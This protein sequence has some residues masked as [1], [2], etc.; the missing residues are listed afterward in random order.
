MKKNAIKLIAVSMAFTLGLSLVAINS[1]KQPADL[2]A[3]NQHIENYDPYTYSGNYYSS[4]DASALTE[5]LDG[6]LRTKLTTL[7][8]PTQWYKYSGSGDDTLS[9]RLQYADEDPTDSTKMVYLYTRDS[10]T[11]NAASTWNR[12]HVWPQSLSSTTSSNNW[13]EGQAGA[14]LLHI[15]PTYNSTNSDRSNDIYADTNKANPKTYNGMLYG[16]ETGTRFEPLD[17]AKGDVA[18]IIMYIW[19]AYKN[20]YQNFPEITNVFESY[21]TLLKWHT[22]DE[23][24]TLEGNRNDYVEST[25]QK[26]R[27]PFVDHPEY[28]WMIF[29]DSASANI[30]QQCK[31]KYPADGTGTTKTLTGISISGEASNKNYYE[32]D[33]FDPQGLTVTANYTSDEG[34]FTVNVPLSSCTWT[35]DPLTEGVTEVTCTYSGFTATYSGITVT[36]AEVPPIVN[37]DVLKVTF[38]NGASG[39]GTAINASDISDEF[40]SNSLIDTI[41]TATNVYTGADGIRIGS[42]NNAGQIV[43][44]LKQSAQKNI[45]SIQVKCSKY[46]ASDVGV[47]LVKYDNQTITSQSDSVGVDFIKTF[48][49]PINATTMTVGTASGRTFVKE[50]IVTIKGSDPVDPPSSSS[51]SLPPSSTSSMPSSSSI[52]QSSSSS[53]S[54]EESSSSSIIPSTTSIEPSS[55][56]ELP[57]SSSEE[58]TSVPASSETISS[59]QEGNKD[60]NKKSSGCG[61]SVTMILPLTSLSA[62]I[63]LVFVLSK[64]KK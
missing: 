16:Y 14:D 5:G 51:S 4:V 30:K 35:P 23:P 60:D 57:I 63:G 34:P 53:S 56:S 42:K 19:V 58:I 1:N 59:S 26:N 37:G 46:N 13:G 2:H 20:H 15:R 3:A 61:G 17:S 9:S 38:R 32:G 45:Q 29:G 10:V 49:S 41:T 47:L 54:L 6:S 11:K 36:K 40:E 39:S 50:I 55:S 25:K 28:A 52:E 7:I 12:E 21:D 33:S 18:R 22:E 43:F 64:K 48:A 8:H 24:D 62:L 31:E 44:K 27:N